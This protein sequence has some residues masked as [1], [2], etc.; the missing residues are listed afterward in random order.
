M[1]VFVPEIRILY[2]FCFCQTSNQLCI[3]NKSW[4]ATIPNTK[5]NFSQSQFQTETNHATIYLPL[6]KVLSKHIVRGG[7]MMENCLTS[8]PMR[9]LLYVVYR[10]VFTSAYF[11]S[12][13]CFVTYKDSNCFNRQQRTWG[14]LENVFH[15]YSTLMTT[16][17]TRQL[18]NKVRQFCSWNRSFKCT[19]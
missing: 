9:T 10:F 16:P 11:G 15:V 19:P 13:F 8:L 7:S 18:L 5:S 12:G 2:K 14:L 6:N 4:K 3:K 1:V 17:M